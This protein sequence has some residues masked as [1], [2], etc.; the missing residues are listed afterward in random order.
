[1]L[2]SSTIPN[3]VNGVSQQPDALRLA[4]QS[5]AQDNFLSSVVEGLKRRPG[6]RHLAKMT[7][8]SWKSAF[9]HNITRDSS[10][11][12]AVSI[13]DGDLLVYDLTDGTAKTVNF[14]NGKGYLTGATNTDFR[15]VTVADF[16]FII[17]RTKTV[18]MEN[19]TTPTRNPQALVHVA[20]GNYSKTFKVTVNGALV[21][22]Y[23]TPDG[24]A[25]SHVSSISTDH[26]ATELMND[27]QAAATLPAADWS[28]TRYENVIAIENT[29]GNDFSI[30]SSDGFNGAYLKV[31]THQVQR[32]SDLPS[33]APAGFKCEVVGEASSNFD[34]YYVQWSA[35]SGSE[36]TGVWEETVKWEIPFRYKPST[37]PHILVRE[38][39]G[40][41]TFK[42]ATWDER[43]VGDEDSAPQASFVGRKLNDVFFF[44][45]RLG[46]AAD[47]NIIMSRAGAYYNFWPKTV[48]TIV[49]SDPID[50]GVSH[51][52]VS[53]I[54][55]AVP[56]NQNLLLFSDQTQFLL[57][58][59]DILS[60]ST[61]S[62]TSTTEFEGS[63]LVRP[64]G[65]GPN[66]YFPVTRGSY[67]GIREYFVEPDSL[68][69]NATDVTSHCPKYV[70]GNIVVLAS[71]SNEDILVALSEDDRRRLYVYKYFY[72]QDGKL[73]SAWSRWTFS[74]EDEILS[75]SFVENKM[76][77]IVERAG[78]GV[79]LEEIDIETGAADE[80]SDKLYRVDR[81]VYEADCESVTYDGTE[82]TFLLPYEVED[83]LWVFIRAG[84]SK[85]PEGYVL[86][87]T[88]PGHKRK[89]VVK[90]DWTNSKVCIGRRFES[91]YLFSTFLIK[92][93]V[94][95]GGQASI[96]EGRLQILHMSVD[97]DR[98][99]YF[100]LH[101]TPTG[102]DTFIYKFTGRI[103][104]S[105]K[106]KLGAAG[107]ETGRFK[108]PV[109]S[110]NRQVQI[111]IKTDHFLPC[112][113]MSAEWEGRY[114]TRSRRL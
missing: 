101:V 110:R 84:D 105:I 111:E 104:G 96:G 16:T 34:N 57:T 89:V 109:L 8:G 78:D 50:I 88:R 1:M 95:G 6:T 31:T 73:Q 22:E 10:E 37:M 71:S 54:N 74:V 29:K 92:E 14:P 90:G 42:E 106:N 93:Q 25:S 5:E 114:N 72:G 67:S 83:P 87:H 97:Y 66:I 43:E 7:T 94:A 79:F 85:Y 65:A 81:K 75:I 82:T 36:T 26:I 21:A 76:Y 46:F 113:F 51:V 11:R 102:R 63:A 4:S 13:I 77:L 32:F 45:N 64:V 86:N 98:S 12:Y 62:V 30:T 59:G 48:T 70:P 91:S 3:L 53:V 80:G 107:L 9:L 99:G 103:L 68:T 17:N 18:E 108:V 27:L 33:H 44:K 49:D 112:S 56:F 55:H 24:S 19:A 2:I 38:A 41:F 52:K 100:E 20:G 47:E 15:A 28:I 23:T 60:P 40:T 58:G 61:V 35:D 39:D 69:N